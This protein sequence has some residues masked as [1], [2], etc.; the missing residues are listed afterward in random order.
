MTD[1]I[2]LLITV[3]KYSS[4]LVIFCVMVVGCDGVVADPGFNFYI[5]SSG[6]QVN[7]PLCSMF[8]GGKLCLSLASLITT[9]IPSS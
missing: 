7:A 3:I 8:D 9:A 2:I 5:K 4:S 1:T 6:S